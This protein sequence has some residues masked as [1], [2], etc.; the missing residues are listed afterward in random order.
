MKSSPEAMA[1]F[2]IGYCASSYDD[3]GLLEK[4]PRYV[5]AINPQIQRIYKAIQNGTAAQAIREEFGIE[6]AGNI[7]IRVV[8]KLR[9]AMASKQLDCL[10]AELLKMFGPHADPSADSVRDLLVTA[11][12]RIMELAH[13]I[14]PTIADIQLVAD[15]N[16]RINEGNN[17]EG[18]VF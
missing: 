16:E 4:Q 8:E 13:E 17:E 5:F 14:D 1:W 9:H 6:L 10:R 2:L 7:A 3:F 15:S 18:S 12:Q 11:A